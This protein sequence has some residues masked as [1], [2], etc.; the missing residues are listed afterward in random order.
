MATPEECRTALEGL[1]ARISDMDAD[2]R[3]A[4]MV[5]RTLSC[6]IPD[7]GMTYLT[8]LGPH[9]ADPVR[10]AVDGDEAAQVR[11][12]ANSDVVVAISKDPGGLARAWMTGRL[13]VSGNV[14]DLMRLRN[15]L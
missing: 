12:I 2:A 3:A 8:R 4:H 10:E 13:K 14:F 5:D 1:T 6:E 15:L 9:G 11:F 7:I